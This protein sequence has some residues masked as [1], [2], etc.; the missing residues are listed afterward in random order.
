[1]TLGSIV[2]TTKDWKCLRVYHKSPARLQ[3]VFSSCYGLS[4]VLR[5]RNPE[6]R[7]FRSLLYRTEALSLEELRQLQQDRLRELVTHAFSN[8]PYYREVFRERGLRPKDIGSAADLH[9][10]PLLDKTTVTKRMRDL[11]ARNADRKRAVWIHSSGTTGKPFGLYV[12]R[13]V[14]NMWNALQFRHRSWGG[15]FYDR[16]RVTFGGH[17]VVPFETK[18]PPFW[19]YNLPGRQVHFST[20]H[21][22]ERNLPFYVKQLQKLRPQVIDGYP[23]AIYILASFMAG[24]GIEV[25]LTAVFVASEPLYPQQRTAMEKAFG[26]K[27]FNYYGLAERACSSGECEKHEGN[28]HFM[29]ESIVEI[30]DRNGETLP[31]GSSGEIVGTSLVNFTLPL[32]R[33]RTG[34]ICT[35][36][37]KNCSCGRGL[38][39]MGAVQT[40]KE[41]IIITPDG[42]YISPSVLTHP[43]KPLH[44]IEKTQIVQEDRYNFIVKIVEGNSKLSQAELNQLVSAMRDR[45]GKEAKIEV[46]FVREIPLTAAGKFR[47][48]ISKVSHE[49]N[50]FAAVE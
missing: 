44:G 11:V 18:R 31:D 12:D 26:C 32:I 9:K 24:H 49:C 21:L 39:L 17:V 28:H 33:Y 4:K 30:V 38:R 43:L 3:H 2:E 16:L 15:Y 29:E 13:T 50:Q 25:P 37:T 42:R 8:V 22:S 10:L 23:S 5:E 6:F 45:L 14:E 34:D 48:V 41:D 19:R 46:Q 35:Y 27:V 36:Q 47:F 20:F 40:K 1:M 7:Y